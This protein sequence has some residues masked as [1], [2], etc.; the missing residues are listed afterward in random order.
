MKRTLAAGC[1]AATLLS[2]RNGLAQTSS[3]TLLVLCKSTQSLLMIDPQTFKVL[4]QAPAGTDPHEVVA[5]PDG[6]TA[7]ISNYGGPGS[8]MHILSVVDLVTRQ[9]L[10]PI[11]LGPL[12]SSHGLAFSG[13]KLYFTV[14][15][16]KAIGRYDPV[17]RTVDW[18]MGTGQDRTHMIEV[19]PDQHHIFTSN[20]SSGTISLIDEGEA[21]GG[22]GPPPPDGQH[23]GGPPPGPPRKSWTVTNVPAGHGS[24]G[25][26]V[27]PNGRELWAAN[28]QDA[29]ITVIDVAAKKVLQT[30]PVALRGAN[31]LK[32][33][34]DG[35]RVLVSGLGF[36]PHSS[37][38]APADLVVFDAV[39]RQPIK[40]IQ[41]GGGAAG[42]L[43]DPDGRR[44]F[45][46]VSGSDHL[47]VIDLA[48]L[49]VVGQVVTG[50]M[51]DG[52][53]WAT[54]SP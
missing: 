4:G 35:K 42:I 37:G 9:A 3:R 14:E 31:R 1:L 28:A 23:R 32:F 24:E 17:L 27:A 54:V 15:T 7:Y 40:Q 45:V 49:A 22:F 16:S 34:P 48:S 10:P 38:P 13:N 25:F 20:V 8:D 12:R 18:V 21:H 39:T 29:T 53:A 50:K 2:A 51:P 44:A 52:M 5:S 47:A 43:M 30:L 19:S 11:D 46:A 41:L 36:G 6:K 26:D 33:T